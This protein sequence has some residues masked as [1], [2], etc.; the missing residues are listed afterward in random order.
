MRSDPRMSEFNE[1]W[2][3]LEEGILKIRN[4]RKPVEFY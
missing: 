4:R 2:S 1:I 3:K